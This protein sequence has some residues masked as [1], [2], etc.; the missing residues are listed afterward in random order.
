M[1]NVRPDGHIWA[2]EFNLYVCFSFR[3]NGTFL[4]EI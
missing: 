1:A 3:G 4:A 2:L